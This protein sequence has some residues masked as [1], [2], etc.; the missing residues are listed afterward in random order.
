MTEGE[1]KIGPITLRSGT[2]IYATPFE[3]F[4]A[5]V[6][7]NSRNVTLRKR[8]GGDTT[9]PTDI[10]KMAEAIVDNETDREIETVV[11]PEID[12]GTRARMRRGLVRHVAW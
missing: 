3:R 12:E 4:T 6:N 2:K 7:R 1:S 10:D 9:N 5:Y 11:I 8:K